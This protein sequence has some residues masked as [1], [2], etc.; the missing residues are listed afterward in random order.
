MQVT[1]RAVIIIGLLT[2]A[3]CAGSRDYHPIP[4]EG[5]PAVPKYLELERSVHVATLHFPTGTYFLQATD[6]AGYYY[7]APQPV[8]EHTAIGSRGH[9]GGIYVDKRDPS[10]LRGY[11]YWDGAL[12]HIGNFSGARHEFRGGGEEAP[13]PAD[14]PPQF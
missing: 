10:K 7:A 14:E 3:G 12:T 4:A 5:P 8:V 13:G 11:V 9:K 6:D 2:L 1:C